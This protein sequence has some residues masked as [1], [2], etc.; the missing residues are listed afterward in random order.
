M[1][2]VNL[3][4]LFEQRENSRLWVQKLERLESQMRDY[5]VERRV[6]EWR[7]SMWA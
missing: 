2:K 7:I 6:A 3:N 4:V 1:W 5:V